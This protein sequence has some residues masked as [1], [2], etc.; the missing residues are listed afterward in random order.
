MLNKISI[1]WRMLSIL[2]GIV[3]LFGVMSYFAFNIS[4][5]VR[6]SGLQEIGRVMME[7][8]KAKVEVS[9]HA[10][11]IAI[12]QAIEKAGYAEQSEKI[13]M[14]RTMLLNIRYEEDESGYFFVYQ[15]TTNIAFPVKTDLQGKDLGELKDKND[16]Y[17]IKEL[18]KKAK[19]GGGFVSYIWPKPG[20]GD[21]PKISYAEMIP[22]LDMWVGTGVYIDNIEKSKALADAN[23]RELTQNKAFNMLLIAGLIFLAI[24][25]L[26][27]IIVYGITSG[28]KILIDNF[29][30]VTEGDGDLTKR[31]DI[32]SGDELG[33]LGKLFNSFLEKLQGIIKQI[34][35]SSSNV[36]ASSKELASIAQ[37]LLSNSENTSGRATNVSSSAE[38]MSANL[39]SVA[40][41]ME[42]SSTNVNMVATA[43]EEMSSTIN[44]IA[45]N[46]E[47][48][49]SIA[50]KAVGQ[51]SKASE[52]MTELGE[53]AGKIS[54]VT[55]TITEISEQT[56][57]L[58]LN[59]T[60]EAARAGEAGKG[61]AV[62]ANEIKELAKQT[63]GAILDI[64]TLIGDVQGTSTTTSQEIGQ[65][66]SVI[67]GVNEIVG[68]IATAVEEQAV[69]TREIAEN[70]SQASDGIQEVNENVSQS[71]I[72]AADISKDIT[73]V[74]SS[75]Q[76]ISLSST[77]VK[78][79]A[80]DL[81]TSSDEL[82]SIVG[83][84]KI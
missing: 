2:I 53:A 32:W 9:S 39:N 33:Q 4:G 78:E 49:R 61:F 70:I 28:L 73:E 27:I 76:K 18:D 62:V 54:K 36:G 11:A 44:E 31:I 65:I 64:N 82:N 29:R 67:N 79:N 83:H 14:I 56:N 40:A 23:L 26:N 17:V 41:A 72:V 46:A 12:S 7:D 35:E 84:F 8:Q 37:E 68:A 45:E 75:A 13:E 1:K 77:T 10:M 15:G 42:Q 63:A 20:A 47:R 59:A 22:G 16:V 69:A 60:I 48:G 80:E 58:A 25:L 57:L 81:N 51:A 71:S 24:I 3:L 74:S 5:Q 38:E 50:S 34:I 66:S 19:S 30:D 21:T 55:E 6:D 43:A 52:K